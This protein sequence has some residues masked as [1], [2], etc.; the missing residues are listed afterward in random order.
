LPTQELTSALESFF[1]DELITDIAGVVKSGKEATVYCCRAG[2]TLGVDLVAAKIYRPRRSRGFQNDAVYREGRVILDKRIARAVRS[3]SRKGRESAFEMWLGHEFQALTALH[4]AGADV[5]RPIASAPSAVLMEY[6]G[7]EDGPALPLASIVLDR[8]EA[9]DLFE[10][11]LRN[12][13]LFLRCGHIHADLSAFNILYH[14]G[15]ATVIDF[16]QSVDPRANPHAFDLLHRDLENVCDYFAPYGI[17][18]DPYR[19]CTRIW[20]G[21]S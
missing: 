7:G 9:R 15:R 20:R 17:H 10:R 11:I 19:L 8:R 13:E 16:P 3:K 18:A 4:A 2:R 21:G 14:R 1:E 6:L 12:V 5:P